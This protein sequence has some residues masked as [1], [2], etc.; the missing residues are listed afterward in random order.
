[1]CCLGSELD[2]KDQAIDILKQRS[3]DLHQWAIE[4]TALQREET[5]LIG[6]R[7]PT[8]DQQRSVQ[9]RTTHVQ[10]WTKT[11]DPGR[12]GSYRFLL[13]GSEPVH[14]QM[15]RA[16]ARAALTS[17]KKWS[18][19]AA[20]GSDICKLQAHAPFA[21]DLAVASQIFVDEACATIEGCVTKATSFNSA[22]IF[23]SHLLVDRQLSS[24]LQKIEHQ[25]RLYAEV[26]FSA[27]D[28]TSDN[29]FL[30]TRMGVSPEQL[31]FPDMC[32]TAVEGARGLC[33]A[34][35]TPA[36]IYRVKLDAE[37]FAQILGDALEAVDGARRY[38]QQPYIEKGGAWIPSYTGPS[39][40]LSLDPS[41]KG[42][43]ESMHFDASGQLQR[44]L[45]LI[46]DGQVLENTL[47]T[48]FSQYLDLPT[49]PHCGNIRFE[50]S[51]VGPGGELNGGAGPILKVWQFSGLFTDPSTMTFSSEI[52]LGELEYPDGRREFVK[53]GNLTGQFQTVMTDP[54][55]AKNQVFVN[56]NQSALSTAR[57]YLGP[58][59]V[60]VSNVSVSG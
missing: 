41:V 25:S 11:S 42:G 60:V 36:G 7:S 10:I 18:F 54:V 49:T 5:Y 3:A 35:T 24:G 56:L 40:S 51:S 47:S 38:Y 46:R 53:G 6:P 32:K 8:L 22:E 12:I 55:F 48:Q 1:M 19:P 33:K 50:V 4:T 30:V 16:T 23:A 43:F 29:E 39:F 26:C 28:G 21:S 14:T 31:R 27:Q 34:K 59:W 9:D 52:R 17:Q 37:T 20:A 57:G 2:I 15:D 44:P 13:S 45:T 58:E